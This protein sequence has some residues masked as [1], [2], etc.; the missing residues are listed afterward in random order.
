MKCIQHLDIFIQLKEI[1]IA[2]SIIILI[3]DIQYSPIR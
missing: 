2:L 3:I 1:M